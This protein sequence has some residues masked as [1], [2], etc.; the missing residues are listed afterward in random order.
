MDSSQFPLILWLCC[1]DFCWPAAAA[2]VQPLFRRLQ[3]NLGGMVSGSET[4]KKDI[5]NGAAGE[6]RGDKLTRGANS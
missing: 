2:H 3:R 5:W 4:F 6:R 1:P